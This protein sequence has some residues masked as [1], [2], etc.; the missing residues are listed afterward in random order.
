MKDGENESKDPCIVSLLQEAAAK[1]LHLVCD[2]ETP[3]FHA[4]V[5]KTSQWKFSA[6]STSPSLA[7]GSEHFSSP[8]QQCQQLYCCCWVGE[9]KCDVMAEERRKRKIQK[10]TSLRKI[11]Q[12]M[13]FQQ[14]YLPHC[15]L[16]L[17]VM[18]Y[19]ETAHT[20]AM[21]KHSKCTHPFLSSPKKGHFFFQNPVP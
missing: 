19:I 9:A 12:E 4:P 13:F 16:G 18:V 20:A 14:E 6:E 21:T 1:Q 7:S 17:H 5:L 2:L 15:C 11:C 10:K 8:C 3:V